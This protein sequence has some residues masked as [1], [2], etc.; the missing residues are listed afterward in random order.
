MIKLAP[1][2]AA[3]PADVKDKVAKI[4]DDIAQGTLKPFAG[5]ITDQ[6]GVVRVPA[7]QTISAND[8]ANMNYLVQGVEGLLPKN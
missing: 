2:N 8:L 1:L 7:G 5:P 4:T 3:I 6:Q